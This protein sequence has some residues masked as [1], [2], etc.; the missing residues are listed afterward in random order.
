MFYTSQ[1]GTGEGFNEKE[2]AVRDFVESFQRK[3]RL[4][5]LTEILE[6]KLSELPMDVG[7]YMT[8]GS[9]YEKQG[10]HEKTPS[11]YGKLVELEPDNAKFKSKLALAYNRAGMTGE[12][13]AVASEMAKK[14]GEP[15]TNSYIGKVFFECGMYDE[16]AE[17]YKKAIEK[18]RSDWEKSRY[19]F[20]L[21]K[22]YR[23]AGEN[24]EAIDIYEK[25]MESSSSSYSRDAAERQLWEIYQKENLFDLAIE[26]YQKIVEA[27]PEDIKAHEFLAK[28]YRGNGDHS[29]AI[30][31][32]EKITR[33][34]PE[35]A[36]AF[37]TMG[38]IY[39]EQGNSEGILA[40]YEEAIKLAPDNYNLHVKLGD[41]YSEKGM[42][43]EA[44]A[45]YDRSQARWLAE[46]EQGSDDPS[47]YNRVVRFYIEKGIKPQEAISLAQ[48]S[49]ALAPDEVRFADTLASAYLSAGQVEEAQ[50]QWAKAGFVSDV[51]W[52]VIGP[53]DNTGGAGFSE[54]YPPEES[55]DAHATYQGKSGEVTWTEVKDGSADAHIDLEG[56]FDREEWAVV[57]ALARVTVLEAREAQLRVGHDDDVKVW[58]NGEEVLSRN[59][60]RSARIDQEIVPVSLK[61]GVNEILVKVCNR[62]GLWG[63]Y[64]R[65]TDAEGSP[66]DD[67]EIVSAADLGR[68]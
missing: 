66:Y 56:M 67:L 23:N 41:F 68:L 19:R 27:N 65:I 6:A 43:D 9:I 14:D 10:T 44:A 7:L 30:A 26:K 5:E 36:R 11:V 13:I 50:Q 51:N 4:S 61:G 24:A 63:F 34:K 29:S 53:F 40:C 47:V 49:V 17:E 45:E 21:A 62:G 32:Y 20:G 64:L 54:V 1:D 37:E 28:A 42:L 52:L 18:T 22:C 46:I 57:Y 39:K 31:E 48:K 35:D 58:L 12:A 8:L 38:D 15:I 59:V 16:A 55:I 2:R 25:I 3:E 60:S 33:L